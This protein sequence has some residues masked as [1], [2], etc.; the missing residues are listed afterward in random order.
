M[1]H[2]YKLGKNVKELR[3][4]RSWTQQELA[5]TVNKGRFG[6]EIR[7]QHIG[8]IESSNGEKLPSVP[9]LAAIAEA[10]ETSIDALLGME[11]VEKINPLEGLSESDQVMVMLFAKRL[12]EQRP[13]RSWEDVSGFVG[14]VGGRR[15][16][17]DVENELSVALKTAS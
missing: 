3:V 10:L 4:L 5:D 11:Q 12:K 8:N 7:Q 17:K 13:L 9:V 15:F 14:L 16:A 6:V 1:K 2:F